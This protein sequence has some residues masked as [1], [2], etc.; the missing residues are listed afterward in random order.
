MNKEKEG[1]NRK[2]LIGIVISMIIGGIVV[3]LSFVLS[4]N[5]AYVA[6]VNNRVIAL[7]DFKILLAQTK[8][9]YATRLQID[10]KSETGRMMLS[11]LQKQ[12]IN[13]LVERELIKQEAEKLNIKVAGSDI[14]KD[15][16]DIVKNNFGGD[17]TKLEKALRENDMT[18]MDL[19]HNLKNQKLTIE[20]NKKV[21]AKAKVADDE[22][23]DYYKKNIE[24]YKKLEE[25][26][27]FHILVKTEEQAKKLKEELLKGG[28]FV[29]F[30]KQYSL[31]TSNKDQGGDLGFFT[32][33][34]MVKEFEAAAW[35][36]K[37]GEISE[38]VKTN[39]GYH[40]IKRGETHPDKLIS[41]EEA[42]PLIKDK[43]LKQK[44]QEEY[45][46]WLENVKKVSKI[47]IKQEY[48]ATPSP[49]PNPKQT[50]AKPS[51]FTPSSPVPANSPVVGQSK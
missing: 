17:R 2:A 47:E 50:T 45:R 41:F 21:T 18:L 1:L 46:K 16:E 34:R 6:K 48:L 26:Q 10:F 19:R 51:P 15:L 22:L 30:A 36:L 23:N 11:N 8:K 13:Q 32:K 28:D 43:I 9:Q 42:K 25:I 37:P 40:I 20:V 24:S 44:Q 27:A 12:L 29:K 38:P 39:Y 33:G 5:S 3:I 35:G 4:S 7:N 49:L 31:D 14:D